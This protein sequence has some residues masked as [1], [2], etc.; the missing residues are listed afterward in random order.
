MFLFGDKC[1]LEDPPEA[2]PYCDALVAFYSTGFPLDKARGR[3]GVD[4]LIYGWMDGLV[5]WLIYWFG[6]AQGTD[7]GWD[8]RYT[9]IS[10]HPNPF[11]PF[12]EK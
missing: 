5:G 3:L 9:Y 12:P 2:W 4:L 7:R 1:I 10:I 11:M 8:A 6:P